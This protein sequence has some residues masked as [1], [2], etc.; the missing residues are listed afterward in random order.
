M[1]HLL[2]VEIGRFHNVF[3]SVVPE[4][5]DPAPVGLRIATDRFDL[6]FPILSGVDGA[7]T[8]VDTLVNDKNASQQTEGYKTWSKVKRERT[9]HV[10]K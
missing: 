2:L 5:K 10:E 9:T 1:K 4:A 7:F 8:E 3:T 6:Q